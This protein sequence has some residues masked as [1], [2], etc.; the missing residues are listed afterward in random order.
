MNR[1]QAA[2]VCERIILAL[3]LLLLGFLPLAF[4]GRSQLP[5]GAGLDALFLD[6]FVAAQWLAAIM[7]LVWLARIWVERKV[8]LLWPPVTWMVLLFAA[9]AI[10]RYATAEIEYVA[11]LELLRVL[12]YAAI[13]L[14]VVN[15]L[16][17][18][19][20]VQL[21]ALFVVS[22]A[23]L[24]SFYAMVQ[25]FTDTNKVWHLTKPYQHR[26]SGTYISPN[27]LGGFLELALPVA[28]SLTVLGRY[29]ALPRIF[30]GYAAV[31][32]LGG[33]A[34]T[35]SRGAWISTA[36]SL[37]FFMVVLLFHKGY[38][39]ISL[40]M[41]TLLAAA[42]IFLLPA[43]DAIKL[44]L[45]QMR[46]QQ[47]NLS[48]DTRFALWQSGYQMW[49]ENAWWGV[50]PAHFD[51]RF[52]G[53]RPESVQQRPDRAHNDYLNTLVDWGAVGAGLVA[54]AW[55]FLVYG[56]MKT[57]RV[58]RKVPK[59]IGGSS[60]STKAAFVVGASAG[61]VAILL[62]SFVDFNMHV[63]ANAV[64]VVIW[65]ALISSHIRFATDNYWF[66]AGI[67]RRAM[68]S[69]LL[70]AGIAWL[71]WQSVRRSRELHWLASGLRAQELTDV[72]LQSL[73]MAHAA[74]PMNGTTCRLIGE[75]LRTRSAMGTDDYKA[76]AEEAM[77]WFAKAEARNPYDSNSLLWHG[78]CLDWLGRCQESWPYFSKAELVNPN[79]YFTVAQVGL[80]FV[81]CGNYAAARPWFERSLRLEKTGNN[82][83]EQY[84]HICN[85]RLL[86]EA[87]RQT[88]TP[89]AAN[90]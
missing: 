17:R 49:R 3:V 12:V 19:E 37:V 88:S 83:A 81:Q 84:L 61:L 43:S 38:R 89:G 47:R 18:Q 2:T 4:G 11:R 50:G 45:E 27:H 42:G 48:E 57:W 72:R 33:I 64:L 30:L 63:P 62:H 39:L 44:R 78:W 66:T 51:H 71:G 77:Q 23:V 73:K 24:L 6:P 15:N 82:I 86:T 21:I 58:V 79:S 5:T 76:L 80:H 8:R 46:M 16:H 87:A 56:V 59:D 53:Y 1:D 29:K 28:L 13:F 41:L 14:V 90:R 22:L 31:V 40:G 34:V 55:A 25:F 60:Q 52:R 7:L 70:A 68:I 32:I 10:G 85:D 20:T 69:A 9:Y 36:G 75:T 54:L 35:F 74:E 26:G 65:F 67:F